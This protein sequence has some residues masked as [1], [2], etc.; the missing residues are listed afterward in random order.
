MKIFYFEDNPGD[1]RLIRE[2]LKEGFQANIKF[3][4]SKTLKN[5]I[6]KLEKDQSDVILLDLNLIDSQNEATF[7]HVHEKFPD[8]PIVIVSGNRNEET[9]LNLVDKG[10]QDYIVKGGPSSESLYRI[11][12]YSI[13][14]KENEKKIN[15]LNSILKIIRNVNLII[16]RE[17]DKTN[18]LE[19]IGNKLIDI[20]GSIFCWIAIYNDQKELELF[21][22]KGCDNVR[23]RIDD[24]NQNLEDGNYPECI[25]KL[26]ANNSIMV[27]KS[28]EED[29][30]DCPFVKLYS[31]QSRIIAK[32]EHD[33]KIYGLISVSVPEHYT[34]Y[35]E[36]LELY[37]EVAGDIAYGLKNLE[38]QKKRKLAE[39]A[40]KKS[41]EQ[42]KLAQKV[43]HIGHW[44]LNPEI[45]IPTW[46]EEVFNI[47]GINPSDGE[48][49][50]D[51]HKKHIHPDDWPI[52]KNAITKAI[53]DGSPY[54]NTSRILYPDNKI[55]WMHSICTTVKDEKG[56]VTK[57]FGTAQDITKQKKIEEKLTESKAR[58]QALFERSLD[59]VYIHDFEGHFLDA[60]SA[61]LNTLGYTKDDILS[62]N[63]NDLLT[64]K[65]Q[66]TLANK[67]IK[68]IIKN[69]TQEEVTQFELQAKNGQ[70]IWVETKSSLIFR[71]GEPYAIQG[72]ARDITKRKKTFE[73]LQK[74]ESE[75]R[76]L[77]NSI[78]DSIL[79]T[80]TKR[81]I[82]DCNI[83]FTKLFG[84][85]KDEILGKKTIYVYASEDEFKELGNTLQ[86]HYGEKP[87]IKTVHYKKK[88]GQI[89]PGETG[90]YYLKNEED[91]VTGFIGLIRDIAERVKTKK[92]RKRL[93]KE[94]HQT[95]KMESIGRLAGAI[96]HDMNNLISPIIGYSQMLQRIFEEETKPRKYVNSIY[97]A[98]NSAKNLVGQLLAFSRKQKIK[99]E[100]L[101]LNEILIE[102]K[103]L[104][105]KTI[106]EDI[107]IIYN[108]HKDPTLINADKGQ[109][110]Q[111]IMNLGVNAQDAMSD[112]GRLIF[113]T[114]ITELDERY[115]TTHQN[116]EPGRYV[117]LNVSDTGC[118]M[119]DETEEKIFEP[120]FSTKGEQGTGM[121]LS[122]VY[123]IIKQHGGDINVYS[124][125]DHGTTF[126]IYLPDRSDFAYDEEKTQN[127][128]VDLDDYKGTETILIA[129]DNAN[130]REMAEEILTELGY[131]IIIAQDGNDALTKASNWLE[132][133]DLLLT[134]VIMPE[135][136]GKD[137]YNKVLEKFPDLK[138]IYMSG[139]TDDVIDHHGITDENLNFIQKPFA[140]DKLAKT[141]RNVLDEN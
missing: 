42:H 71:K 35:K 63:F 130:T 84:Y 89:F 97:R 95:Q 107:E 81:N 122:T 134:D 96:A 100:L 88:S 40:L 56:K 47:F 126:K 73:A 37:K 104:L 106:R 113:E 129:E 50:I 92:E 139:Y 31:D 78:R 16:T 93:E 102:F 8:I 5:G 2:Q 101:N 105:R 33:N 91:E 120:F 32:I 112:G 85:K 114:R 41:E 24:F 18:L 86:N 141:V 39:Q 90:V 54:E 45:G 38:T 132:R 128:L 76:T 20:Q 138:V 79:V 140:L 119:D 68:D 87:F 109:I 59:M 111:V 36:V 133:I 6:K 1:V 67:T 26:I 13:E 83:A 115:I 108:L 94:L 99:M 7:D 52:L 127:K 19:K 125:L 103:K 123:G 61:A 12:N 131:N 70:N 44:E 137:L 11:I 55:K 49:T 4:S 46:S 72:V 77:F 34:D 23:N 53:Q 75:Y 124:E 43:A 28:P 74:S 27:I 116:F 14:R 136:N 121:G 57:L 10:A 135:M 66:L 17:K 69:G 15:Y 64:D 25:K 22:F 80:D 82:T 29:C 118:G 30:Q 9:A 117:V 51:E 110:E 65:N 21:T 58:Y 3:G 60:N 48:P 62:L 98:G